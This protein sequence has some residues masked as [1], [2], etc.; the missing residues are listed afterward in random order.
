LKKAP[1]STGEVFLVIGD[2]QIPVEPSVV[3]PLE[4]E[5]GFEALDCY[6]PFW[7]VFG[8]K[9]VYDE[10]AILSRIQRNDP[11]R[12]DVTPKS[13]EG[14]SDKLVL[15]K[16]EEL[17]EK[18]TG[19]QLALLGA[20]GYHVLVKSAYRSEG[21]IYEQRTF[22]FTIH[23]PVN[24]GGIVRIADFPVDIANPTFDPYALEPFVRKDSVLQEA[25]AR[26]HKLRTSDIEER[27][28]KRIAE[29]ESNL[30]ANERGLPTSLE[31]R[32][33]PKG[34]D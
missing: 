31:K 23:C 2:R 4:G 34:E 5:P 16:D 6:L 27:R 14:S 8:K 21:A 3:Y 24:G 25:F 7:R 29:A 32:L 33:P 12:V 19:V 15:K 9:P 26:T 28:R 13:S 22:N 17:P 10:N 20:G 11:H 18:L 1:V 30:K